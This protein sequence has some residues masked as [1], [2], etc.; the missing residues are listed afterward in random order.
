MVF[1][2]KIP[3]TKQDLTRRRRRGIRPGSGCVASLRVKFLD[4]SLIPSGGVGSWYAIGEEF[5]LNR[6][7]RSW[8]WDCG[9]LVVSLGTIWNIQWIHH[10]AT[11]TI[12]ADAFRARRHG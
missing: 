3:R 6:L 8:C 9:V 11:Q 7:T 2:C 1:E 5:I 4:R 10:G 12:S